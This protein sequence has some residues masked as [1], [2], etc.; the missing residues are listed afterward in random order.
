MK[1]SLF[2]VPFFIFS[3]IVFLL[4]GC[5]QKEE[6]EKKNLFLSGSEQSLTG[7]EGKV[8][9]G[10][11]L[12]FGESDEIVI[13][14][15]DNSEEEEGDP[16]YTE[17]FKELPPVLGPTE[18]F[19]RRLND[20]NPGEGHVTGGMYDSEDS[21]YMDQYALQY[22]LQSEEDT[23]IAPF[24]EEAAKKYNIPRNVI[25]AYLSEYRLKSGAGFLANDQYMPM[26]ISR[27][28]TE[29]LARES[30]IPEQNIRYTIKGNIFAKLFLLHKHRQILFGDKQDLT[31]EEWRDVFVA[32]EKESYNYVYNTISELFDHDKE[33][34]NRILT[35]LISDNRE[36]VLDTGET[37]TL[38]PLPIEHSS[39]DFFLPSGLQQSGFSLQ[40]ISDDDVSAPDVV[41]NPAH[42]NNFFVAERAADDIDQIVI[43]A[44]DGWYAGSISKFKQDRGGE[45]THFFIRT[46]NDTQTGE[47]TQ[48]IEIKDNTYHAGYIP[49][50]FR[51]IGIEHEGFPNDPIK[52]PYTQGMYVLSASLVRYLTYEYEI[53]RRDY[54]HDNDT[55]WY[56][57]VSSPGIIGHI[58]APGCPYKGGGGNCHTDPDG[59]PAKVSQSSWD[60]NYYMSLIKPNHIKVE[61]IREENKKI[62]LQDEGDSGIG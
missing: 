7:L 21:R 30:G 53:P 59:D 45:G 57:E 36:I 1:T 62:Q 28:Q 4:S 55:D 51:S 13:P 9:G 56:K 46:P 17:G 31:I 54:Y 24:I 43:H 27:W 37:I 15:D 29:D 10:K 12:R 47:I 2:L 19:L 34:I 49:T 35:T 60:W 18:E 52:F 32:A 38:D 41:W 16:E 6:I 42:E 23:K 25:I 48:M 33:R 5:N 50:S 58:Q 14:D 3:S 61:V 11:V 26:L 20:P 22:S 8:K 39:D 44:M 40:S